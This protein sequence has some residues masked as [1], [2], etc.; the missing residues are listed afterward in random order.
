MFRSS[1]YQ[2][3]SPEDRVVNPEAYGSI[4]CIARHLERAPSTV[5]RQLRRTDGG[6]YDAAAAGKDYCQR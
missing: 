5:S 1:R 6:P 4:R 2:H 3:L